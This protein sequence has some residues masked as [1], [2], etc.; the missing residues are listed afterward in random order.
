MGPDL[1]FSKAHLEEEFRIVQCNQQKSMDIQF[2]YAR[3]L[4]WGAVGV[5]MLFTSLFFK[6]YIE[7][8]ITL[9]GALTTLLP[10][11]VWSFFQ[12]SVYVK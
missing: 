2:H 4:A 10:A 5:R 6:H 11:Y 8:T 9:L 7:A 1:T 3:A 12:P